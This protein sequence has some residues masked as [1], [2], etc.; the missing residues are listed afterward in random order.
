MICTQFVHAFLK[1]DIPCPLDRRL[2]TQCREEKAKDGGAEALFGMPIYENSPLMAGTPRYLNDLRLTDVCVGT[3]Q[4]SG[5]ARFFHRSSWRQE[6]SN[7]VEEWRRQE[8]NCGRFQSPEEMAQGIY[9]DLNA[10]RALIES[11]LSGK[12]VRHLCY[13]YG[14]GSELSV[15]LSREAGFVTNFWSIRQDRR[16]NRSGDDPFYCT[17]LKGDYLFRLPGQGRKPL[18]AILGSKASRRMGRAVDYGGLPPPGTVDG[19]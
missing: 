18:L 16:S 7:L 11:R 2:L 19:W 17:R 14:V 10:S 9:E 1:E 5:G 3:V 4:R 6:L 8:H 12:R 13:P 15:R